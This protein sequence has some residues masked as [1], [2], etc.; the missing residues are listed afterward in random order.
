MTQYVFT[1][2]LWDTSEEE[3]RWHR[4]D[5]LWWSDW[6]SLPH[7]S[8]P[9]PTPRGWILAGFP[10]GV[11]P[12]NSVDLGDNLGALMLPGRRAGIRNVLS[13]GELLPGDSLS[14]VFQSLLI[15]MGD[16]TSQTRWRG[17]RASGSRLQLRIGGIVLLDEP[18]DASHPAWNHT[19]DIFRA[20]YRRNRAHVD[21]GLMP[22]EALRRYTG[23]EMRKYG[24]THDALLPPEYVDDGWRPPRTTI[25]DT[26]V[27][28]PSDVVLSSHTATGPNGGFGWTNYEGSDGVTVRAA[29]DKGGNNADS[30]GH[31]RA[32]SDLSSDEHRC[33]FLYKFAN[34]DADEVRS[35][36]RK[37]STG[38]FTQYHA[39]YKPSDNRQRIEQVVSGTKTTLATKTATAFGTTAF[40]GK[41]DIDSGDILRQY[42]DGAEE[43]SFDDSASPVGA[44]NLRCGLRCNPRAGAANDDILIDDFEA[45]DL[46]AG[47]GGSARRRVGIGAGHAIRR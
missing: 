30:D 23:H 24:I 40:T 17:I 16:P 7:Q 21:A 26:M 9:G 47:G 27:E 42:I 25:G 28:D 3:P 46:A 14:D 19:R 45:A 41:I 18:F 35:V 31:Y 36:I 34:D 13:L 20:A 8:T 12:P 2:L 37:D 43:Q 5:A 33:E 11:V 29:S 32:D 38:T 4:D 39:E 6:R 44:G 10:T 22:L 1:Q 15:R